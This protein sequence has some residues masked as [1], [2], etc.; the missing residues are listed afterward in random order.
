M[1]DYLIYIPERYAEEDAWPLVLFLH[2]VGE[3]GSDLEKVKRH[4][5]PRL[6]GE[7]RQFPFL[8]VSPQCPEGRGWI[9]AELLA[10]V[11]EVCGKYKVDPD[12]VYITGL[13]MGGFGTWALA[14]FAPD[15]FAAMVPICGGGDPS[16]AAKIAQIPT[17]VFHG[18]KD[19]VVPLAA[20]ERM[21]MAME[22]QGAQVRFTVYPEAEHDSWTETYDNPELYQWLLQQRKPGP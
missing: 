1:L 18:A 19:A 2:G 21:V 13:S 16:T 20:S 5:P 17:W 22:K 7:G 3:R 11:D 10:M 14:A 9:P 6:I 15:R 4:G 12:R 8:V